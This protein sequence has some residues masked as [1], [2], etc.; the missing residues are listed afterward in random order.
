MPQTVPKPL[1]FEEKVQ[2]VLNRTP[3]EREAMYAERRR[4]I[5]P[6]RTL[7]PGKTWQDVFVGCMADIEDDENE[8]LKGLEDLS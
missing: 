6:G 3:E 1:T 2:A 4:M 5:I 8:I 7:P